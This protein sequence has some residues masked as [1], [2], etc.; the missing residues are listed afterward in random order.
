MGAAFIALACVVFFLI[1]TFFQDLVTLVKIAENQ[2]C[3]QLRNGNVGE[4]PEFRNEKF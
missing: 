4:G 2:K 1:C 3:L